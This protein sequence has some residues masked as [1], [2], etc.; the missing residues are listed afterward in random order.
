MLIKITRQNIG[1]LGSELIITRPGAYPVLFVWPES[2]LD[3]SEDI[4]SITIK[5]IIITLP[6]IIHSS[7]IAHFNLC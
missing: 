6:L 3:H 5:S 4:N 2:D 1:F 7:S